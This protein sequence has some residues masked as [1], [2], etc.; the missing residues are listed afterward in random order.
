MNPRWS[1]KVG[2]L[3]ADVRDALSLERGERVLAHATT[4]GGSY[5]AVTGTALYLPTPDE[6]FLRLPWEQIEHAQWK[7]GWLHVREVAG[8]GE[9][10]VGLAEPGAVPE[11]VQERVIATIVISQYG[12]LPGG[13]GVRIVGRRGSDGGEPRWT[14]VF[15][16]GLDPLDPGLR[17]QA[18]QLLENLRRQTG[19]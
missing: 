19:L 1:L 12:S 15:D 16:S 3:P 18:E 4:R 2:R 6:G 17:A 7:D 5:A 14:F 8:A 13:G 9:H 11:T 10:H